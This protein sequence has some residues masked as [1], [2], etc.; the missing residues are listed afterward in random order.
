[1]VLAWGLATVP[2]FRGNE[3]NARVK[4]CCTTHT[5]LSLLLEAVPRFQRFGTL[6]LLDTASRAGPGVPP[7]PSPRFQPSIRCPMSSI[8]SPGP[9]RGDLRL[10]DAKC[11]KGSLPPGFPL[12][13]VPQLH[14]GH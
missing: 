9:A 3:A 7:A 6:L 10:P 5:W 1:M 11:C 2:S 13:C 14:R 8:Q 4:M 12:D